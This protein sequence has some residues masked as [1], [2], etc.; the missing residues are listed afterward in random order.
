MA[1]KKHGKRRKTTH[2]NRTKK[3]RKN[4][5]ISKENKEN[6]KEIKRAKK[7][8]FKDKHPKIALT[9]KILIILFLL[10]GVI[11]A[12][13]LVG[14]IYGAFGDE[15]EITVE[16]LVQPSS[17]SIIYDSEG[18]VLAE[19]NG[20][21][22]RKNI[23]LDEMS[24]YL[25][26]AY[27]AI[28]DERFETHNGVD[29]LRTGKAILT[30]VTNGGS[31]SFGG[32]T[33]TQQLV[34]NITK[35]DD[36]EGVEGI[37]RKVKEWAKAYQIE[38]MISKNQ[39]LELYLNTIFVGGQNYGVE[40]GAYYY[41]NKSAHDL[42][43]VECA[44]LAGINSAPNAYNPYGTK[45]YG[46]DEAKTKKINNKVKV[47][48]NKML[49]V[50]YISQE[51]HDV[52]IKEV[53]EQGMKFTKGERT[54]NYSYHTD[55]L[56]NQLVEDLM[57][58]KQLSKAAAQTYLQ[59]KG[60]KIYST[61]VASIQSAAQEAMNNGK[62]LDSKTNVD[63]NGN[64]I[65]SQ[66]GIVIIDHKTGYVLGCVGGL[67]EKT[68]GGFN[69]ATQARRRPGS[70]IKPLASVAVGLEEKVITAAT[71]YN[72]DTTD[73]YVKGWNPH[74]YGGIN[75][76]IIS[77]RQAIETSQNIPFIK[78]VKEL[79]TEK[80]IDYLENFG[81]KK[82]SRE[83]DLLAAISLGGL[84][85]GVTP[86]EMAVAYGTIAND[87]VYI[88]PTFYTKVLDS[89][90]NV[91]LEAKQESR[92]V[93]SETTAYLT[94]NILTQPVVGAKGTARKCA[95]KNMDV[96]AK[97][98][99]S[100]EDI[101]R[102]LCGFTNYYTAAIWYG[103]DQEET[104]YASGSPA[105]PIWAEAMTKIHEGLE[106]S[107]FK[108]PSN[109]I[110][111][112][113]C[114]DSGKLASDTCTNTYAEIFEK[115]TIP[116]GCKGHTGYLICKDTNLLANEY[117]KNTEM[118]YKTYLI[119]KEKLGLWT[120][121]SN[122]VESIIPEAYC[123]V[124]QKP[125]E[126]DITEKPSTSPEE[127]EKVEMPEDKNEQ[128][129]TPPK[130]EEKP[131]EKPEDK[132]VDNPKDEPTENPEQNP[133]EKPKE[134]SNKTTEDSSANEGARRGEGDKIPSPVVEK[135]ENKIEQM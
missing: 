63:E 62:R 19:L 59:T 104:I 115:G 21:E 60:L 51:E 119:E 92:R 77:I 95:I 81:I 25:A 14:I 42:T 40:T 90:G 36:D 48:I 58:E 54:T 123:E 98:G 64:V 86:L 103:F 121:N 49:E 8:K 91:V 65:Q 113:I 17:N 73:F 31:S 67:G 100:N 29:F 87:G 125:V 20:D 99:T 127:E 130:D 126:P 83:Q 32:S 5:Y 128:I 15:F 74:N 80:S 37:T 57:E 6:K 107:R 61:E 24:Q 52:A 38:R 118:T 78:V 27:V 9:I 16:E 7:V 129:T 45:P 106:G 41:F 18:K 66:A 124:H 26:N 97:T 53:N 43:L 84:T 71:L 70:T 23:T 132:P 96:A 94:K 93:I 111:A 89:E 112:T 75:Y 34:K 47:V 114:K 4:T 108:V 110:T 30:F 82:L 72:D 116:E 44:F 85:N 120:T 22:N 102:W 105:T 1:G 2:R 131:V 10:I 88:E 33:I 135:N 76:G 79:T 46:T 35:E 11:G 68:A 122:N 134:E 13:V 109:I 3:E 101:D 28:E 50:G 56:I 69:R 39:I 55:A 117:C 133:T 12:G